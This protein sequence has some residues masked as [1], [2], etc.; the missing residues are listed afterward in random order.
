MNVN[1]S[2]KICG[3]T[4]LQDAVGCVAAGCRGLGFVFYRKSP[5]Y[6]RPE[7]AREITAG[8]KPGIERIGVFVNAPASRV[9]KIAR[10]CRLTMLQFHG[11]ESPA[12]CD[13][14]KQYKVIKAFRLKSAD[15]LK[16]VGRYRTYGVLF[17]TY[18]ARSRGGTG[19]TGNWDLLKGFRCS[20]KVFLAGG[21]RADTVAA[22]VAV[23]HPDWVDVSSAVES[24]PGKKDLA[25][26][27]EFITRAHARRRT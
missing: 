26:V 27:K 10:S 11:E 13:G 24:A 19:K 9:R 16:A 14:F 6:V 18:D 23:V 3:I 1:V 25:K 2:V 12:Y 17:D 7:K 15:G 21:L 5:R 8:L 22:A 4:S 20:P